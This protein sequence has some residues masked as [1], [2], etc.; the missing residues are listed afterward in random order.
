M[1]KHLSD[2]NCEKVIQKIVVQKL[3]VYFLRMTNKRDIRCS[4][5]N[6]KGHGFFIKGIFY[7]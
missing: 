1:R 3:F 7:Q 6:G 4:L 2:S 5:M